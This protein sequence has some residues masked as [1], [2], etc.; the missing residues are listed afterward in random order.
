MGAI[1][2]EERLGREGVG[3]VEEGVDAL[4]FEGGVDDPGEAPPALES[5]SEVTVKGK[6]AAV[7]V[8]RVV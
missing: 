2:M 4:S 3:V 1:D 5:L 6:A 8:Y 7:E